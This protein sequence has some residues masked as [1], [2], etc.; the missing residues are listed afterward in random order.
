M[1]LK[2][3]KGSQPALLFVIPLAGIIIWIPTILSPE[4][5]SPD[6]YPMA[7]Y[8]LLDGII[9]QSIIV[10]QLTGLLFNIM[11]A[12]LLA[13]INTRFILIPSRTYL[14]C[15]LFLI[16][17]GLYPHLRYFHPAVPAVFFLLLATG[18]MF[19]A[20]KQD[21]LSYAFFESALLVSI[22]GLFYARAS[23]Y[24]ILVWL[25][26]IHL[27]T[28]LWREWIMSVIGFIVPYIILITVYYVAGMDITLLW[29][30]IAGNFHIEH[31]LM[32]LAYPYYIFMG[33]LLLLIILASM[34]MISLY[35]GFKILIRQFS[36]VFFW[37]FLISLLL[38]LLF[39][40]ESPEM[41][42]IAAIPAAYLLSVYF[43]NMKSR[44]A[45]E[46]MFLLLIT[47]FVAVQVLV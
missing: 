32:Y 47:A 38:F 10:S 3:L 44:I 21:G 24:L 41:V 20:Y 2:F 11:T 39:F 22:A 9:N 4:A 25:G 6:P 7:L 37:L 1:I 28:F 43:F 31:Q 45:G 18:R 12:F 33:F 5:I 35:Q 23:L 26:L 36:K 42:M 14:P 8:G 27:R 29:T 17:A 34:R 19:N 46:I 16:I 40:R 30:I 13:R 15:I